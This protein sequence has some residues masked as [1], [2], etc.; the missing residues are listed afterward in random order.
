MHCYATH[1]REVFDLHQNIMLPLCGGNVGIWLA[2]S[3]DM[4]PGLSLGSV[5]LDL[6]GQIVLLHS[7][8][9]I[10]AQVMFTLGLTM[11]MTMSN[12]YVFKTWLKLW[13]IWFLSSTFVA[14]I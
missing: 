7:Q 3:F 1:T 2:L 13:Y 6:R 8:M 5:L 9:S 14:C 4:D 11:C 10:I 12:V